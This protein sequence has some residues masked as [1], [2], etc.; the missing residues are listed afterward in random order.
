MSLVE[1]LPDVRSLSRDEKIQLIQLLSEELARDNPSSLLRA[2]ETY[3]DWSPHT[4]Y[5]A[6]EIL[7]KMLEAEKAKS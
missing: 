5:D 3:S 6:A 2:G 7:M 1:L 4:A